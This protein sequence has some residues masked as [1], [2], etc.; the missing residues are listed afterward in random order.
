MS[1]HAVYE[2]RIRGEEARVSRLEARS[3]RYSRWRLAVFLLGLGCAVVGAREFG[4]LDPPWLFVSL[5]LFVGFGVLVRRH[6]GVARELDAA[7]GLVALN[8]EALDRLARRWEALPLPAEVAPSAMARDLDLFGRA[9][10]FQF[11]GTVRTPPG[12]A[13]MSAWLRAPADA[14]CVAQRLEAARERAPELDARQ[15]FELEARAAAASDAHAERFLE[16][17]EA[18]ANPPPPARVLLARLWTGLLPLVIAAEIVG[19][20]AWP[21]WL[22][23]IAVNLALTTRGTGRWH[24]RFAAVEAREGEYQAYRR[25]LELMESTPA[26]TPLTASLTARVRGAARALDRLHALSGHSQ[27]RRSMM[28]LPVQVLTLWDVHVDQ[29]LRR[30]QARHGRDAR[31]WLAALGEFEAV[32]ALAALRRDHPDWCEPERRDTPG[33]DARGLGH[34]LLAPER[35]VTNDVSLG[36]PGSFLLVTGSNMS[37]KS[38]LLRAIGLNAVLAGMGSVV[39][40]ERFA[41]FPLPVATSMR[42]ET[43]WPGVC[44]NTWRNWNA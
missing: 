44:L 20:V 17:A 34:P 10:L 4:N 14:S 15:A 42:V 18:V 29:A 37:G 21:L 9:S 36:E 31:D 33:Y 7:R 39:C 35:C 32:N 8:R 26:R 40:A 30:W 43:P 38:T 22:P 5:G 3:L 12:R 24:P 13:T 6:G 25:L 2:A 41:W 19:W 28:Y 16:W 11:L 1:T 27:L 23:C